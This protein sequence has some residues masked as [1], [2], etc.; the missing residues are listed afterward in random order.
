MFKLLF[1]IQVCKV[2]VSEGFKTLKI[3]HMGHMDYFYGA[4]FMH[5][6]P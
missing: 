6:S 1:S 2:P 4:F 5:D 3:H